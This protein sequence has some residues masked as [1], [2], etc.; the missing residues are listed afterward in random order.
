MAESPFRKQH[1]RYN[2][3][4]LGFQPVGVQWKL[5]TTIRLDVATSACI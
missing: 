5:L 3:S 1:T 4:P 2:P